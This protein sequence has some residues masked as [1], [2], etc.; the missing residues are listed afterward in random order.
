M[1]P[2][3]GLSQRNPN[4]E[5]TRFRV[6]DAPHCIGMST[7]IAHRGQTPFFGKLPSLQVA[8]P[9]AQNCS[10][11]KLFRSGRNSDVFDIRKGEIVKDAVHIHEEVVTQESFHSS[12]LSD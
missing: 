1:G 12:A 2:F 4:S 6:I 9:G 10:F 11:R 3:R 5:Q 7:R 8:W